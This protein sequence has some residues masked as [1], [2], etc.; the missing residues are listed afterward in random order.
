M[1]TPQ[2]TAAPAAAPKGADAG[3]QLGDNVIIRAVHG[4][5]VNP[6]TFEDYDQGR[7]V[8]TKLDWWNK[9][10][11]EHGKLIITLTPDKA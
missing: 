11:A 10:Q 5:M 6:I 8:L 2:P 7:S 9:M 4:R 3:P 1:A